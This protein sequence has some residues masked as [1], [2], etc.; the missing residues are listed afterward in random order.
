[1]NC[2]RGMEMGRRAARADKIMHLFL[3]G[4]KMARRKYVYEIKRGE[5]VFVLSDI[6]L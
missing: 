4:K 6:R 2:D 3:N 5:V 1:M